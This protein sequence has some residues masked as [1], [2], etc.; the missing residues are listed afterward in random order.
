MVVAWKGLDVQAEVATR[1]CD[2]RLAS[3][4]DLNSLD[5]LAANGGDHLPIN[6]VAGLGHAVFNRVFTTRRRAQHCTDND[7]NYLAE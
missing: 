2:D 6:L 5:G 4:T 1:V 7:T 3:Q